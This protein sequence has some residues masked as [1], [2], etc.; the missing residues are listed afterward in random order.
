MLH[1]WDNFFIMA[2]TAGATLIGLL[3]VAI[4]LGAGMSTARG[5]LSKT[6][7]LLGWQAPP[8]IRPAA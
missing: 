4:T 6:I 5:V 8:R 1:G 7:R 3:F 2:G